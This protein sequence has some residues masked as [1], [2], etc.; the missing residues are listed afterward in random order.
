MFN[1]TNLTQNL[2]L[3]EDN[4]S[5]IPDIEDLQNQ[6]FIQQT[7]EAPFVEINNVVS[8]EELKNKT[9]KR[10]GLSILE[11]NDFAILSEFCLPEEKTKEQD[12]PW[13]WDS[14]IG[15][16]MHNVDLKKLNTTDGNN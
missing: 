6:D 4:L 1:A 9:R 15:D 10:P 2:Y 14:L 8:I 3:E 12:V 5:M 13:T 7:A 16:I 11:N